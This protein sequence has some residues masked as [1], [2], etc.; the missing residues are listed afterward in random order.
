MAEPK[1][2]L[3]LTL[4]QARTLSVV[5]QGLP[6]KP[7]ATITSTLEDHGFVRTLGGVD[8]YLALHCRVPGLTRAV[9][10]DALRAGEVKVVPAVRGCMYLVARSQV[11][12]C[13]R[14][15]DWLSRA[16]RDRE[17]AKVGISATELEEIGRAVSELLAARGPLTTDAIRRGLPEGTVRS[18]GPAGK[19]LGIS[20]PLP[21]ALRRLEMD[22]RIERLPSDARLDNERYSWGI[23][24]RDPFDGATVPDEPID[25]YTRLAELFFGAAGVSTPATF[26]GWVGISQRDAKAA[27]ARAGL[28]PVAAEG[29]Q[30]AAY[31]PEALRPVLKDPAAA[32][33]VAALLPFADNVLSLHGGPGLLTDAAYHAIHVP[34]WGSGDKTAPL[35]SAQH[36]EL[37]C[38]L[39]GNRVAGVWEFD[40]DQRN[41]F[42]GY[43]GAP[44]AD[45][46]KRVEAAGAQVAGFLDGQMGHGRSFSLDT[47]QELRQRVAFARQLS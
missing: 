43:F 21:S 17:H 12:L 41:V 42:V 36:V 20:S 34:Q 33:Q 23:A 11:P 5:A 7:G 26:A 28:V 4:E 45:L 29:I 24:P 18:L 6:A 2:D 10:D 27:I 1:P 40:P 19:K 46:R 3:H 37:R 32:G 13:L 35:V 16:T 25:A 39:G 22:G 14:A 47:D 8:A 15:A 30:G 44:S 9:V 38:V 31:M